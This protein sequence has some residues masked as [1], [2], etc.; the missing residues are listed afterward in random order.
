MSFVCKFIKL[1]LKATL[2]SNIYLFKYYIFEI[3]FI[4]I[5]L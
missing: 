2:I 1:Y 3:V 5:N 4:I